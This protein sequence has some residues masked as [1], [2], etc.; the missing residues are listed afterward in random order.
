MRT[1]CLCGLILAIGGCQQTDSKFERFPVSGTVSLDGEPIKAG[2]IMFIDP[3]MTLDPDPAEI[4][5]GAYKLMATAGHR[6]V[7]VN[8][9]REVPGKKTPLGSPVYKEVVDPKYNLN[10]TLE[11]EIMPEP[12]PGNILDFEVKSIQ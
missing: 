7:E 3:Q 8:V 2:R 4:V 5:D 6:R 12:A 10:S 1:L 11:A 9:S